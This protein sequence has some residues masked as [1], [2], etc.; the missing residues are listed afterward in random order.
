MKY[1]LLLAASLLLSAVLV[2]QKRWTCTISTD[3][4]KRQGMLMDVS[5]STIVIQTKEGKDTLLFQQI[6]RFKFVRTD[7]QAGQRLIGAA[8]GGSIGAVVTVAILTSGKENSPASSMAGV[9]G[10]ITGGLLGLLTGAITTPLFH[11]LLFAKKI[12][13]QHTPAFYASLPSLLQ[14]YVPSK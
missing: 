13:V 8:V 9:V 3:F 7:N 5:D 4:G 2:A 1:I 10:G 14:P 11:G 6:E 12:W